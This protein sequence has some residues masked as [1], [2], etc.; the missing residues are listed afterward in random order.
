MELNKKK[1]FYVVNVDWFF[2]SHRKA[3][4]VEGIK[5]GYEVYLLTK[6]TGG[7]EAL[8]KL[9]IYTIEVPFDRKK[10]MWLND[11]KVF[12]KL[13]KLYNLHKPNIIHHVTL[14][15]II[16]GTLANVF[17]SRR[18][19]IINA[20]SGLGYAF[21]ENN[22]SFLKSIILLFLKIVFVLNRKNIRFIFQNSSDKKL[23]SK[24]LINSNS[25]SFIIKG[26]GVDE[27][28][29]MPKNKARKAGRVIR[30]T[31]LARMLKDK[32]V[33]EFI[34]AAHITQEKLKGKAI[35]SLVGG[36][37]FDN[38]AALDEQEIHNLLIDNY[39][40][41]KGKSSD[42]VSVYQETDIA[43]LPS[44]REGMPKSL[45]EA[46]SM[47]CAILTTNVPGCKDCV[48]DGVNGFLFPPRSPEALSEKILILLNDFDLIEMMG[49]ESRIKMLSDMTLNHVVKK[50]YEIYGN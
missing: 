22:R 2:T 23:F 24:N 11:F 7:F 30:I 19:K 49:K 25:S 36:L 14:K 10:G 38:P 29:F 3:L 41:W 40:V 44:Y 4:A 39:L 43:C 9:G 47:E 12:L 46:M 33:M 50:T 18:S 28:I 45:I 1:I 32:G 42:V 27:N 35:F 8:K 37:D 15:P 5:Q 17:F 20:V 34:K 48:D 21:S 31:L 16:Y 13:C 26:S 6:N